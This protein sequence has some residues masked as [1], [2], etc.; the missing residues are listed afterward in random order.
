[1]SYWVHQHLGNLSPSERADFELYEHLRT[2]EDP[3]P[4]LRAFAKQA[5]EEVQGTR[6]SFCRDIG[7]ARV[8]MIDSRAGRMRF[9]IEQD[10]G[11]PEPAP[12]D[13]EIAGRNGPAP[14]SNPAS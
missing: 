5:D 12:S 6:W 10:E 3:T 1:M 2:A 8:V 11:A 9:Q 13:L 7:P 14:N 4:R